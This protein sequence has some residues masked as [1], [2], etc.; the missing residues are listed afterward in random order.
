MTLMKNWDVLADLKKKKFSTDEIVDVLLQNRGLKTKKEREEFLSPK[1]PGEVSLK[2]V[3]LTKDAVKKGVDRVKKALKQKEKVVVYGDYDADG[4]CATAILWEALFG[5]GINAMPYIPE[6]FSE[7]YGLNAE[8]ISNLKKENPELSLIITVDNGIV[9]NEA[10][11]KA[12]ELGINVLITDHHAKGKKLPKA[13]AVIHTTEIGGAGIAWVFAREVLSELGK[14]SSPAPSLEL[15]AIGTIADQIPLLYANRSFVK[16]GLEDLAKT[17]RV[18]LNALFKE[19]A[20]EKEGIN[21]YHVNFLI[22]PRLNAMGRMQHAIDSL[23][24]LCTTDPKRA[25]ELAN[26]L[27]E[28][29]KERQRVVEE[30]VLHAKSAAKDGEELSV[31]VVSDES[32]HEGVVGLAASKLVEEFY[33]PAIVFSKGKDVSKASARSI[34]GFNI[35][36]AIRKVEEMLL[37]AGGHP[38]AAG[39]SLETGKIGEFTEKIN[40]VARP[41]LTEDILTRTLKVD[42]EIEPDIVGDEFVEALKKFE[43]AGIG[44]PRPTFLTAGMDVV[45]ARTVGKTGDHLKLRLAKPPV[46]FEA[47]AFNKGFLLKDI[48]EKGKVDVVYNVEENIWNGR[49]SI[50]LRVKDLAT[51]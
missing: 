21:T 8:S 15:A 51:N 5:L 22:A 20:I 14:K 24:L 6:R 27:G 28:T 10:V 2:D 44:N 18:G 1:K 3:G 43:P 33:R 38:M 32:Y 16:Y 48:E 9:A 29:N 25:S 47:I 50:E 34:S 31:I 11:E 17:K 30:V 26:L 39:L 45:S 7:G 35:I 23:R 12:N 46:V 36:E 40:K 42:M 19:A 37:G 41:L 4:I 13:H 49:R